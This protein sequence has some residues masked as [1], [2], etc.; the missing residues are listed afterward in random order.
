MF[1][2]DEPLV[3]A[4]AFCFGKNGKCSGERDLERLPWFCYQEQEEN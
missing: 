3:T 2:N 1:Y 4:A